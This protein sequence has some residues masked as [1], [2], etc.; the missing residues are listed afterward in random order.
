MI[1]VIR[2]AQRFRC[3]PSEMLRLRDDYAAYCLDEACAYVW[4]CLEEGKRPFFRS[5][6]AGASSRS[7]ATVEILRR[8]GAEVRKV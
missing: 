2:M 5:D 8:L 4:E 6:G 7:A 1:S 3:R